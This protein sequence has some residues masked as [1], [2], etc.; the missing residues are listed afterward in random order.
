MLRIKP[1]K[2]NRTTMRAAAVVVINSRTT[3]TNS[4]AP[5]VCRRRAYSRFWSKEQLRKARW[6]RRRWRNMS[7]CILVNR[8]RV[9]I[10]SRRNRIRMLASLMNRIFKK[11][12]SNEI[13]HRP[14]VYILLYMFFFW[15]SGFDLIINLIKIYIILY[16]SL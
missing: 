13:D 16:Y 14:H 2:N 6:S 11:N 4:K 3:P 1:K 15:Q 8:I 5:R 10:H 7:L 12:L 9:I